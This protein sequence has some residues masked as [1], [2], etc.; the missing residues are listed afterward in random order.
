MMLFGDSTMEGEP[1]STKVR[2]GQAAIFDS[3]IEH[4]F[5]REPSDLVRLPLATV[6]MVFL[7]LILSEI[8]WAILKRADI[9]MTHMIGEIIYIA[10]NIITVVPLALMARAKG[11]STVAFGWQLPKSN[12]LGL[13]VAGFLYGLLIAYPVAAII[14][15]RLGTPIPTH[16]LS[17]DLR[18]VPILV[19]ILYAV[20]LGPFCEET[21][22]RGF[23]IPRLMA[24]GLGPLAAGALSLLAFAAAHLIGWGIGAAI[25]ILLWAILPTALYLLRRNIAAS[26][27]MHVL[28]NIIAFVVLPIFM[29]NH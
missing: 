18:P 16:V 21:V 23:A 4:A 11:I 29:S 5:S 13:G 24:A 9:P 3:P 7:P 2:T 1:Q 20:I 10:A 25:F 14:N 8:C 12:D 15:G 6:G 27:T 28:N 26:L 17:I 19:Q 22:F